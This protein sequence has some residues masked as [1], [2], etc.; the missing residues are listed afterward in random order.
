M[1]KN[2][3]SKSYYYVI[4]KLPVAPKICYS[5]SVPLHFQST[6]RSFCYNTVDLLL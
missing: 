1:N 3:I 6:V 4:R 5:I 2:F